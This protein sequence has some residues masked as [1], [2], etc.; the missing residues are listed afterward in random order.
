MYSGLRRP[1]LSVYTMSGLLLIS[2]STHGGKGMLQAS[3]H[4]VSVTVPSTD[5]IV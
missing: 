3:E 1:D 4:E 2:S 5:K